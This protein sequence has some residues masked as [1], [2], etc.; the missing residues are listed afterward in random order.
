M[1]YV[2]DN[3]TNTAYKS[4]R[5]LHQARFTQYYVSSL[6]A[7]INSEEA[8]I[9]LGT[10]SADTS[11]PSTK[12]SD[13]IARGVNWR[14]YAPTNS[15]D[16]WKWMPHE[17]KWVRTKTDAIRT[18][19]LKYLKAQDDYNAAKYAFDHNQSDYRPDIYG[20]KRAK[21]NYQRTQADVNRNNQEANAWIHEN[22]NSAS[23][24]TTDTEKAP[25][26]QKYLSNL[27]D[28]QLKQG[29]KYWQN[30]ELTHHTQHIK[31]G[32]TPKTIHFNTGDAV[33]IHHER[34]FK[35]PSNLVHQAIFGIYGSH[36][37]KKPIIL[38]G[39]YGPLFNDSSMSESNKKDLEYFGN[40]WNACVSNQAT[41]HAKMNESTKRDSNY[42]KLVQQYNQAKQATANAEKAWSST[43]EATGGK[44]LAKQLRTLFSSGKRQLLSI[45]Y[46]DHTYYD[47]DEWHLRAFQNYLP[48][49]RQNEIDASIA[50]QVQNNN[51]NNLT[52]IYREDR[53]TD[54]VIGFVENSPSESM[55]MNMA[56]EPVDSGMPQTN[57]AQVNQFQ[58][59]D[60]GDL[61]N[62]PLAFNPGNNDDSEAISKWRQYNVLRTWEKKSVPLVISGF[63]HWGHILIQSI[64]KQPEA[65]G[66]EN[67]L[68]ISMTIQYVRL[69]HI[70]WG[71]KPATK[72]STGRKRRKSG[73]ST[74][75]IKVRPGNTLWG[76]AHG[77][78][79]QLK[80]IKKANPQIKNPNLI[81][82]GE[83]VN[84]PQ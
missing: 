71:K 24:Y 47:R 79:S 48:V 49:R 64:S 2:I 6:N 25:N 15:E 62:R 19:Y 52:S 76:F 51:N 31:I 38:T 29:V 81:Y 57:Y 68:Q 60:T 12:S 11:F 5:D 82:P 1:S 32:D 44:T 33:L 83:K 50:S 77:N 8:N 22:Y 23:F 36:S 45:Y 63:N 9:V 65:T 72:V 58:L 4:Y 75:R 35:D 61:Y 73:H 41:I 67:A 54:Q 42:Q 70:Q 28:D 59:S 53:Q 69:A 84:I 37:F 14:S 17:H 74:K 80:A 30:Q 16:E 21:A 13:E 20:I 56:T 78:G 43:A 10:Q 3:K 46:L 18:S 34:N 55:D 27:S 40:N 7:K 66:T 39:K 26:M